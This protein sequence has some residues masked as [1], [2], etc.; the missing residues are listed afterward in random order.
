MRYVEY[1][2]NQKRQNNLRSGFTLIEVLIVIVVIGLLA[3]VGFY[4]SK[5]NTTTNS[6]TNNTSQKSTSS[7]SDDSN[8]VIKNFGIDL[9]NVDVTTQAT[10][11]FTKSGHKG[12]Y[13]FGDILP[14]TP[15]R[16][17]PNFEF[18]SVKE[19]STIIS[20]IDG[21]VGFIKQQE[22]SGDYEVFLMP[23]ENSDW[24][25]GYDHV[26]DL[27]VNKGDLV[28]VGDTLGAPARQNNGLLRFEFQINNNGRD[29]THV[30]PSTLLDAS[31]KESLLQK[32]ADIQ[33][34]WETISGLELYDVTT[35]DPTGC[36]VKDMTP[37]FAE[38]RS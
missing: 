24:V 29:A 19:G 30:C 33:K 34:Q 25:I 28:K 12:M 3:G 22:D 16:H 21:V 1:M 26:V 5:R 6:G 15:V 27:K 13:I 36:L 32:L 18:A 9:E 14:G 8:L 2:Q 35:Q 10:R 31:V 11:D 17:N 20:A 38:G 4:V 7:T 37:A 23:S